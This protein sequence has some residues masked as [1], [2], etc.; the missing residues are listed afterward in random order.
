VPSIGAKAIAH[1]RQLESPRA[2]VSDDIDG[3]QH[4]QQAMHPICLRARRLRNLDECFGS[5]AEK[6]RDAQLA[7]K[8]NGSPERTTSLN[9]KISP[10][11]ATW[12]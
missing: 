1:R 2:E 4:P 8:M 7:A 6:V 9:R 10:L 5:V 12:S 11:V 3:R